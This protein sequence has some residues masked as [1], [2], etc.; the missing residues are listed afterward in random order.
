MKRIRYLYKYFNKEINKAIT[1]KN[2]H[3]QIVVYVFNILKY[4]IMKVPTQNKNTKMLIFDVS[5][6]ILQ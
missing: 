1:L 6:K 4:V 3:K 2:I 5:V